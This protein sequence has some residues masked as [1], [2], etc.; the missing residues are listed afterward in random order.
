MVCLCKGDSC[1]E[2]MVLGTVESDPVSFPTVRIVGI[3]ILL[4]DLFRYPRCKFKRT[5]WL[6]ALRPQISCCPYF[7]LYLFLA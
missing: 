5:S 3:L 6:F 4:S 2:D 1:Q 7:V